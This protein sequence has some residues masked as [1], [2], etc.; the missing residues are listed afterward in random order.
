LRVDVSTRI[1]LSITV[2]T[3]FFLFLASCS[4]SFFKKEMTE[5]QGRPSFEDEIIYHVFQRSFY[6]A[7]GDGH[8]D[9][10]GIKQKL[11]YLQELGVTTILLT[12]LYESP[13]YH[14]YFPD[15]F[16]T[17]D[18]TYGD[19]KSYLSLINE[20]HKRDMK[21]L[22]DMEIH[23][24]T[25]DHKWY[26]DSYGNPDS[27]YSDY[28]IYNGPNNTLPE[29]IIWDF[30]TVQTWDGQTVGLCSIDLYDSQVQLYMLE[31]FSFWMD[32]NGDGRFDDGVDG[33]RIDHMV[34]DLDWKGIR[35]ELLAKFWRPL[36]RDL[37]AINP[38]IWFVGEQGEWDYGTKYFAEGLVNAVFAIPQYFAAS[39]LD[40]ASIIARTDSTWML[41]PDSV[42]Q[43]VFME[44]HDIDRLSTIFEGDPEK[45][46]VGAAINLL[47]KGTPSIYYGQELGMPGKKQKFDESASSDIPRREAFEWYLDING[48]G[49]ALWYK[50]DYPWWHQTNLKAND[51]ISLA[52]QKNDPSSLWNFYRQLISIRKAHPAIQHGDFRFIENDQE[53][54]L[55]FL[56]IS[57]KE[58]VIV[59]INLDKQAATATLSISSDSTVQFSNSWKNI[60]E[61]NDLISFTPEQSPEINLSGFDIKVFKNQ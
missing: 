38:K 55:S 34:D 4:S 59:L 6:D 12:P 42:E 41:T 5:D 21:L 50:G 23:Y 24:I 14:N 22:M 40:K 47:M 36:L 2:Y 52:E 8:G 13:F 39:K 43:V 18:P 19:M 33:F 32:P 58:Q 9:L 61:Q 53:K 46:R 60:F 51:G 57:G 1:I 37:R 10:A 27:K 35:P 30:D 49:M 25:Y 48:E 28:I 54:V 7:N 29:S 26:K 56:R 11:D 31:Q 20:V 17:I 45:L 3:M 16:E 15:N 44:N